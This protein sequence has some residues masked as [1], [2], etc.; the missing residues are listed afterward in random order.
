MSNSGNTI[1]RST[2]ERIFR[3]GNH[4]FLTF[5]MIISFYPM[6]YVLFAS[7]SDPWEIMKHRG[8][9]FWPKGYSLA[10]YKEVFKNRS[11]WT[12]LLTTVINLTGGTSINILLTLLGAYGLSR[13]GFLFRNTIMLGITFTMFFSG[14]MI[15]TFLVV[16]NLGLYDNRW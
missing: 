3:L 10:S 15:P 16:K 12:G 9:L 11:I 4:T 13:K 8:L 5:L 7:F 14:G 1:K 2:G 6:L